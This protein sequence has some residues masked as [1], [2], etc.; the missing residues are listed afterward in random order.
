MRNLVLFLQYVFGSLSTVVESE[1]SIA[2]YT[3]EL[4]VAVISI[5]YLFH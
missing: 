3:L 4:M 5:H 1:Q 2:L